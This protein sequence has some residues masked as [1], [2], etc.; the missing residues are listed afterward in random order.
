VRLGAIRECVH[1]HAG[2][3]ERRDEGV[4]LCDGSAGRFT[5]AG[6]GRLEPVAARRL[7]IQPNDAGRTIMTAAAA[8]LDP[9][10][11]GCADALMSGL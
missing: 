5:A 3:G 7:R 6:P 2:F 11:S 10:A 4:E 1:G 9:R 8:W